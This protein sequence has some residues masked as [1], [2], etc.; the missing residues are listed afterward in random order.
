MLIPTKYEYVRPLLKTGDLVAFCGKGWLS[1][2][3]MWF[4]GEP[5]HIEVI[6]RVEGRVQLIG[7]TSMR[8]SDKRILGV[9]RTYLSDRIDNYTGRI[10]VLPLATP[11]ELDEDKFNAS[12]VRYEQKKYDFWQASR[13]LIPFFPIKESSK[14]MFC[15]ELGSFIYQELRIIPSSE[16]ASRTTPRKLCQYPIYTPDYY[17]IK[18]YSQEL[19]II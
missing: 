11:L 17:Q 4:A 19:E 3:I 6:A 14:R 9:Q 2:A 1:R 15:S 12:L 16:N 5:S 18:G 10:Y 7:S 8:I 13:Q